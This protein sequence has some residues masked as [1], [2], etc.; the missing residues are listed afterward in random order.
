LSEELVI[1]RT[2]LAKAWDDVKKEGR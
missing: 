2:K 1:T